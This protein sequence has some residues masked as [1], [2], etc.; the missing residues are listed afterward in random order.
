M[1]EQSPAEDSEVVLKETELKP[2]STAIPPSGSEGSITWT[3]SEFISHHKSPLWYFALMLAAVILALIIWLLTKD[4]I[5]AGVFVV[6]GLVLSIFASKKPRELEYQVDK[7]GLRIADKHYP[8][9][10]F[11]SFA[12]V[13]QG[14]FSSLVFLPLRRFSMITTAYYDPQDE[15]K[16]MAIVSSYLP[17]EE[18]RRD[19]IDDFM[20]RIRF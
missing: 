4:K 3:A 7:D 5:T 1:E 17:L 18:R 14:A 19:L 8:F 12:V 11:R 9:E 6:A 16:I 10:K 20:W 2:V 13:H 15:A